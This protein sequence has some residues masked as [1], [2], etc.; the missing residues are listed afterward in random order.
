MD[1]TWAAASVLSSSR[2]IYTQYNLQAIVGIPKE[3]AKLGAVWVQAVKM[4]KEECA[5]DSIFPFPRDGMTTSE[6]LGSVDVLKLLRLTFFCSHFWSRPC[7]S[8]PA[9]CSQNVLWGCHCFPLAAHVVISGCSH[10]I[11]N[12][13]PVS[14]FQLRRLVALIECYW[15]TLILENYC[16]K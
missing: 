6:E 10:S 3:S 2:V 1:R 8:C 5:E 15:T 11:F 16:V 14:G 9:L 7:C 12:M 13:F 4:T